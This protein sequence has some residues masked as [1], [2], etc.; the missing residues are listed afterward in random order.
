[1]E[2]RVR[3]TAFTGIRRATATGDRVRIDLTDGTRRDVDHLLLGTGFRPDLDKIGFLDPSLRARV[4]HRQ[5]FPV[6]NRWF[7]SSV[8]GLHFAGGVAGRSF[9]PLC[10]FICG[11]Q[12]TA[13]QIARAARPRA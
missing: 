5:G 1:V 12:A 2:G 9:G 4:E 6:L 13:R 3:L 11:S 7:E 8:R 10:N